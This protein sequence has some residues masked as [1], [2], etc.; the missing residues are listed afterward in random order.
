MISV[1]PAITADGK[2]LLIRAISGETITFTRF[3]I[4]N[5]T[6]E[7]FDISALSD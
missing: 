3:K 4:G 1:A 2:N 5:G 7:D 6:A